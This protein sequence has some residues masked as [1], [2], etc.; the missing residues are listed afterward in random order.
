VG[1]NTYLMGK[2]LG[3]DVIRGSGQGPASGF[4]RQQQ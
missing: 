4:I 3:G 2:Q 1:V